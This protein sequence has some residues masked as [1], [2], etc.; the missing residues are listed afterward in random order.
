M[1]Q[2]HSA[3]LGLLRVARVR[4]CDGYVT[5]KRVHH[6]SSDGLSQLEVRIRMLQTSLADSSSWITPFSYELLQGADHVMPDAGSM[7]FLGDQTASS[8]A[9]EMRSPP[10]E[11]AGSR[12][13]VSF[14]NHL[15]EAR[16]A[17]TA[18]IASLRAARS[19]SVNRSD[20]SKLHSAWIFSSETPIL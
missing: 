11:T 16:R 6:H 7:R 4:P 8:W 13:F 14:D 3:P 2:G 5:A 18:S 12:G 9:T 1:S 19:A 17:I 10:S 20:V 15:D